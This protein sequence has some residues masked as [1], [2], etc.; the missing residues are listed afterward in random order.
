MQSSLF[1][2]AAVLAASLIVAAAA[3]PAQ[4]VRAKV[5]FDFVA[6]ERMMPA[7]EYKVALD[8]RTGLVMLN[9]SDQTGAWVNA[10]GANWGVA[11][12]RGQLVFHKYGESYFLKRV[13]TAAT[14]QGFE[15]YPARAERDA[16]KSGRAVQVA[17]IFTH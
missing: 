9:P 16:V 12:E 1:R 6:G 17:L 2:T 7:G 11:N 14:T 3:A 5:P 4:T 8:A 15:L 10:H 13:K